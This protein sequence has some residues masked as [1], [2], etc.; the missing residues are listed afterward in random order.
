MAETNIPTKI[1]PS[2]RIVDDPYLKVRVD[3]KDHENIKSYWLDTWTR[4][5]TF[6][7][8]NH[9]K[10]GRRWVGLDLQ[11]TNTSGDL[12]KTIT[13]P[14]DGYYIINIS[15]YQNPRYTGGFQLYDGTTAIE[16]YNTLNSPWPHTSWVEYKP[17]YYTQGS[18]TFKISMTKSGYVGKF[19]IT[20]ITRFEGDNRANKYKSRQRLDFTNLEFTQNSVTELNKLSM[21]MVM[22]EKYYADY[23]YGNSILKFHFDDPITIWLGNKANNTRAVYGGYLTGYNGDDE[24]LTIEGLDTLYDLERQCI[25]QNFS[26]AGGTG[27]DSN[28]EPFTPFSSVYELT[29]YLSTVADY[30][31]PA[32]N[33]P[34]D[35]AFYKNMGDSG[36]YNAIPVTTW[37]KDLDTQHGN[38]KPS[39]KLYVDKNIGSATAILYYDPSNPYDAMTYDRFTM[40]YYFGG[41]TARNPLKFNVHFTVH[42]TGETINNAVVYNVHFTGGTDSRTI[43]NVRVVKN[44]EFQRFQINLKNL[45]NNYL[46]PSRTTNYYVSKIE[47]TGTVT[48][49]ETG[50]RYSSGVWIDN[51]GAYKE[52]NHA[53]KYASQ[54]VKTIFGE[55][56]QVC[57][58]TSHA[59]YVEYGDSRSEDSL[60]VVPELWTTSNCVIDEG[61]NLITFDGFEYDPPN[62]DFGNNRHITYNDANNNYRNVTYQDFDIQDHY[63][64]VQV[65]EFMDDLDNN[66]DATLEAKNWVENNKH[67]RLGFTLN[68]LGD[69]GLLPLQYCNVN[70]PRRRI[71]GD[72]QVKT[73]THNYDQD[74]SPK[75]TTKVDFG[76]S[77]SR[78]RNWIRSTRSDLKNLGTRNAQTIYRNVS[79][80][81]LGIAGYGAFSPL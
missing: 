61:N 45:L 31:I 1:H 80:E 23:D 40:D 68:I 35:Y 12:T 46:N 22:G 55:I 65:H 3:V 30:P 51:I 63:R 10:D 48:K 33:V 7:N 73:I 44:G 66:N 56:Q 14:Y 19:V 29:R 21:D 57:E 59:A 18:H 9:F 41:S 77:S 38:P 8:Y 15:T 71:V 24:T 43:G 32:F 20:P 17:R 37:G 64:L 25:F 28:N 6:N 81:R 2:L 42:K 47:L 74:S 26:I 36:T 79:S 69:G 60:V 5:V 11:N 39:M 75:Y 53:S 78:F 72:Y 76:R 58:R 52:I 62:E 34:H 67:P 13:L 54:D 27:S 49:T 16:D 4:S 50:S 70:L